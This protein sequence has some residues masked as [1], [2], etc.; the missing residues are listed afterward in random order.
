MNVIQ[1]IALAGLVASLTR[2]QIVNKDESWGDR[3]WRE[4][5]NIFAFGGGW[6]SGY[7]FEASGYMPRWML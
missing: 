3:A 6:W 5:I 4:L 7:V 1:A 2:I